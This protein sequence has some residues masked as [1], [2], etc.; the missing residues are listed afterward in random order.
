MRFA[1]LGGDARALWLLRLLRADGHAVKHFA[2]ERALPDGEAS[3]ENALRGAEALLLPI[4]AA[5]GGALN[6]PYSAMTHDPAAHRTAAASGTPVFCGV[7]DAALRETCAARGLPLVDLTARESFALQNAALTAEGALSLLTEGPDA[8]RGR[9]VL[10]AGCGRVGRALVKR[11]AAMEAAV[12]LAARDPAQRDWA[13]S[14][15]CRTVTP[16]AAPGPGYAAV[17]NTV[18]APLFGAAEL[19]AFGP[20]P[21]IELAG[22]PGG[23]DRAAAAALGNPVRVESGVPGRYA[24]LAAARIIRDEIMKEFC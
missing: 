18:P 10:V 17:F 8:I 13:E 19:A 6:A 20:V 14:L 2:L 16:E 24:P 9:R 5:R 1:I 21:L 11:L 15:G 23:F 22:A 12:T 3:P 7:P 4:P